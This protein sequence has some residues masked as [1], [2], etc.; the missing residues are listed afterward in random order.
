MNSFRIALTL[1][2]G[3]SFFAHPISATETH[4]LSDVLSQAVE[5]ADNRP[6]VSFVS[7]GHLFPV[8]GTAFYRRDLA[9]Q[10]EQY[11]PLP[12]YDS[13]NG[14][15][16]GDVRMLNAQCVNDA[17][18]DECAIGYAWYLQL[19][20]GTRYRLS[21][22]EYS[23]ETHGLVSYSPSLRTGETTW[24]VIVF[25]KGSFWVATADAEVIDYEDQVHLIDHLDTWCDALDQCGPVTPE[26]N[27][28]ML[29][30]HRGELRTSSCYPQAYEVDSV[31]AGRGTRYYKVNLVDFD[32]GV[33]PLNLPKSGFVPV[34]TLTGGHTGTFYPRGC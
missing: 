25:A 18:A 22:A 33:P 20:D 29:R 11:R 1:W 6:I 8:E 23:Y 12:A 17:D 30:V 31:V 27:A 32:E 10:P 15:Q 3:V 9:T 5:T 16:I 13:S 26:M 2:A 14:A 7:P 4:P 34:R 28:E 24:S 19:L 21:V